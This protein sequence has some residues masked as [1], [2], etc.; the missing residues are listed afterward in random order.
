[1][2]RSPL[3]AA[4]LGL[5]ALIIATAALVGF[6]KS[7][8]IPLPPSQ[9][10]S[11]ADVPMGPGL[12]AEAGSSNLSD[13]LPGG[14]DASPVLNAMASEM[15]RSM[16]GLRIKGRAKPYF[17][18]YLLWDVESRQ[19]EASLGSSEISDAD[20]QQYVEVDLRVGGYDED[21]TNFQGGI[22]F[23]PRLRAP[24]PQEND[25]NLLRQ[26]LWAATDARFKVAVELL[27]QKR[28]FRANHHQ[29]ENLP[30]FSRQE[31]LRRIRRESRTPPDTAKAAALGKELS[32]YLAE[33]AW[34]LESRVAFQYYYTTFYYV[35][36][37]GARYIETVKEHTFLASIFTQ[38]AD[39]A[40]L[41]DY[42]RI[43]TR[44]PMPLGEGSMSAA[45]LKDSL[46]PLIARLR[47][48]RKSAPLANYRGPVLF[49]GTA[50]GELI[51]KALLAPQGRLREPL[52][53]GAE[54]NFL[55]SLRN[56]KLFPTEVTI[57]DTPSL[58]TWN[59][60]SLFGHYSLDHQGQPAKDIILVKNGR[61]KDFLLG[62]VPV[63]EGAPHASNGHW[64]Y[65]GGFPGVT[66]VR[67]SQPQPEG[68]LKARL[69]RM[70]E[71]EGTG[72]G[73]VVSKLLDQDAFKL[74]RH[75]L[76]AQLAATDGMG[77]Q[78][79]FALSAPCN[80][81]ML[82]ARTGKTI[83]VRGLSFPVIDSKSLRDIVGVGDVPHLHEPQAAFSLLCPPLL[84]SL[85]DM[86][87]SRSSQPRPPYLP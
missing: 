15:R 70:G 64:R 35:D 1:M 48:L 86:K 45:A 81:D 63:L 8:A 66:L 22:V 65:G 78:G 14:L 68:E 57:L 74:L 13:T 26:S 79:S 40:P 53:A 32:R 84:F 71:D 62:K 39:G 34:L 10:E 31:V 2:N 73:L 49:T 36:S 30:D 24:L 51:N 21:Q 37:E 82:D 56:R 83:P 50:A 17:L 28:A 46:A 16:E 77:G 69:R 61:V 12:P 75:P 4:R 67:S 27:A 5:A 58:S 59:G 9:P 44:D 41:W 60:R 55:I 18:S 42:L 6:A 20:R 47:Q 33:H 85:L 87:G 76:A 25:T 11:P 19:M 72:Y 43:A 7:R 3:S 52:G 80:F 29:K 54:P 23:G 38:A